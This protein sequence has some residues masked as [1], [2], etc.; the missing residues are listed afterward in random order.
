MAADSREILIG[1]LGR[2][3]DTAQGLQPALAGQPRLGVAVP[4]RQPELHR[5]FFQLL[6]AS[7]VVADG[8]QAIRQALAPAVA[9]LECHGAGGHGGIEGHDDYLQNPAPLFPNRQLPA[10]L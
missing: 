1:R 3:T 8:D 10:G 7:P 4:R 6:V 9:L 5:Q 2:E